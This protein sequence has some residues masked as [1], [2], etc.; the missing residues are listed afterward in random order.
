MED[1]EE[2]L[3]PFI[4]VFYLARNLISGLIGLS[5]DARLILFL[6]KQNEAQKN[7][8][9]DKLVPWKAQYDEFDYVLTAFSHLPQHD[10]LWNHMSNFNNQFVKN[11]T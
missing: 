6:K 11:E 7:T 3:T 8:G 4:G 5:Y 2:V 9:Q 1:F 10:E